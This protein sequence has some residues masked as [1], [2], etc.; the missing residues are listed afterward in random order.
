MTRSIRNRCIAELRDAA[1]RNVDEGAMMVTPVE[2][3]M[4]YN[5]NAKAVSV[6][7]N[8]EHVWRGCRLMLRT[9]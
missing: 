3:E 1:D 5:Q 9:V 8:R 2:F 7:D 6:K 4:I